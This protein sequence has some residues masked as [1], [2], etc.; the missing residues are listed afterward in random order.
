[1]NFG[2]LLSYS[3]VFFV[4]FFFTLLVSEILFYPLNFN[5]KQANLIRL[6]LSQNITIVLFVSTLQ[7]SQR[8]RIINQLFECHLQQLIYFCKSQTKSVNENVIFHNRDLS[9][10]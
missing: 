5:S 8:E 1:M 10:F 2:I 6:S 9:T 4:S 7:N 3:F